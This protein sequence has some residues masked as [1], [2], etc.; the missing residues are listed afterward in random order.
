MI[1]VET[2]RPELAFGTLDRLGHLDLPPSDQARLLFIRGLAHAR[3][4][5]IDEAIALWRQVEGMADEETRIKA[6]FAMATT[7]LEH[8]RSDIGETLARLLQMRPL[9]R[10][11]AW[12][13]SMLDRLAGIQAEA[14][15]VFA[16]IRNW[17]DLAARHPAAADRMRIDDK[18]RI[19]FERA[20]A[21]PGDH[22]LAPLRVLALIEEQPEL[23]PPGDDG[24]KLRQALAGRL[25]GLD[26]VEPAI[27]L[28]LAASA[29]HPLSAADGASLASLH[30]R[31][32]DPTAALDV[33]DTTAA[34]GL[35][36]ELLH[37]RAR[38]RARALMD[39]ASS[40]TLRWRSER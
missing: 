39:L 7:L 12:E 2:G 31:A 6:S 13:P 28:F 18:I 19:T 26:L 40:T 4:G 32:M 30:L 17:Q 24:R 23:M 27:D 15:D 34:V 1:S 37:E 38:L 29:G 14:G 36:Q 33:L 3:V 9:W 8:G 11:H 20:W 10:G 22:P 21:G 16:A 25:A 35:D 5:Q